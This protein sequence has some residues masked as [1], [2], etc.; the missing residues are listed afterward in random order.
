MSAGNKLCEI[1]IVEADKIFDPADEKLYDSSPRGP[2]ALDIAPEYPELIHEER[3]AMEPVLIQ[4]KEN[5]IGLF[6][7][8]VFKKNE[9]SK[10]ED[11][12]SILVVGANRVYLFARGGK[13]RGFLMF[14]RVL[15]VF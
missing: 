12:E 3:A 15:N 7:I 4:H 8:R 2:R 1:L 13:V 9:K 14:A 11:T 10:G 5:M 6:A